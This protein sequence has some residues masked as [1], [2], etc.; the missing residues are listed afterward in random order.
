M[1]T[2]RPTRI[3]TPGPMSSPL[4]TEVQS[5]GLIQPGSHREF[6]QPTT[7]EDAESF[8]GKAYSGAVK[9][10]RAIGGAIKKLGQR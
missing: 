2:R 5:T 10:G 4:D 6:E 9:A 8:F 3:G 1:G 7:L